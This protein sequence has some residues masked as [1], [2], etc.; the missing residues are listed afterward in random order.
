MTLWPAKSGV[1]TALAVTT[2]SGFGAIMERTSLS[3][4]DVPVQTPASEVYIV[5]FQPHTG[6]FPDVP[7]TDVQ[8]TLRLNRSGGSVT[9]YFASPGGNWTIVSSGAAPS[10]PVSMALLMWSGDNVFNKQSGGASVYFRNF[11]VNSGQLSCPD[12]GA[13][14]AGADAAST[15]LGSNKSGGCDCHLAGQRKPGAGL[16]SL[17]VAVPSLAALRRR[18]GPR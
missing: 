1:R 15:H 18:R 7:T 13:P 8:G 14:D 5:D 4:T 6:I 17:L 2:Q 12:A 11:A 16:L 3:A 10:E 9:G